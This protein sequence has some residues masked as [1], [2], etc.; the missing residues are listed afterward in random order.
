MDAAAPLV[1][2]C[3]RGRVV[4]VVYSSAVE[5]DHCSS[6]QQTRGLRCLLTSDEARGRE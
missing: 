2:L 5:C 4:A 1:S 3:R 6:Q